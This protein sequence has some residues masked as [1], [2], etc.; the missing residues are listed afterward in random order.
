MVFATLL[1]GEHVSAED[2]LAF[3]AQRVDEAPAK[4]KRVTIIAQM[5]MTNVGKIYKPQLRAMAARHV[6]QMRVDEACRDLGID[7]AKHPVVDSDEHHG[8][9]VQIVAAT[10]QHA[11]LRDRLEQALAPLPVKTRVLDA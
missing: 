3:T 6:V 11:A 2:L 7:P 4:P 9:T 5:P 8:V 1:P 10:P